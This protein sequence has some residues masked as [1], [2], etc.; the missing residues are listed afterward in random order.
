MCICW[1][2]ETFVCFNSSCE[3]QQASFKDFPDLTNIKVKKNFSEVEADTCMQF[4]FLPQFLKL[5]AE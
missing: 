3:N 1:F 5:C 4:K 2:I